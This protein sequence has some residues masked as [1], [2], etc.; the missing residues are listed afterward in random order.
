[1]DIDKEMIKRLEIGIEKDMEL[2]MEMR[3]NSINLSTQNILE[4]RKL[5]VQTSLLSATIIGI[6]FAFGKDSFFIKNMPC[7]VV[8]IILFM[9]VIVYALI[10]LKVILERENKKLPETYN[11]YHDLISKAKK[12][13][14][15]FRDKILI[16]GFNASAYNEYMQKM[17]QEYERRIQQMESKS[18]DKE[19]RVLDVL[20]LLFIG[21]LVF[22]VL[23]MVNFQWVGGFI[24]S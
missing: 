24:F 15:E 3:Q 19:S 16:D 23:S 11:D 8:A 13:R 1:M 14:E 20:L 4:I 6:L 21:A 10:Y 9:V 5:I 18:T 12:N 2:E 7:V 17:E 22:M